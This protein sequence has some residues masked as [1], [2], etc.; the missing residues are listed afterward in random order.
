MDLDDVI[1]RAVGAQGAPL[2]GKFWSEFFMD[3]Q[4]YALALALIHVV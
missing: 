1:Y 4:N 2:L 3:F